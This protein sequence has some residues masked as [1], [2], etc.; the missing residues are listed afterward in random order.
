MKKVFLSFL[1]LC[2]ILSATSCGRMIFN[3]IHPNK[4]KAYEY[5]NEDT[6]ASIVAF[7]MV[8]IHEPEYYKNIK[9]SVLSLKAKGYKMYY[10]GLS[11]DDNTDSL[12]VDTLV[13]KFRKVVGLQMFSEK[14]YLDPDNKSIPKYFK[15][16]K[17]VHQTTENVGI[18]TLTDINADMS[19][20]QLVASYEK[21]YGD[22]KLEDC[23]FDTPFMEE[24]DCETTGNSYDF[25]QTIR[26]DHL[27][28][29]IENSEHKKIIIIYGAAHHK[30][31]YPDLI[32]QGYEPQFK[33][34]LFF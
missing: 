34:P 11:L 5:Y 1:A 13:R 15:K 32:K 14:G 30:F 8:H 26:N 27:I 4:M 12:T 6:K 22:I 10:E 3:I 28:E 23:D 16:E 31:L 7:S 19:L 18:D 29:M 9:D 20:N 17:F 2:F 25:L 33:M 24:Y 21:E